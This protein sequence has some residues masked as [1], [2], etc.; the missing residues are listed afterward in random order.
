[1]NLKPDLLKKCIGEGNTLIQ[2][3]ELEVATHLE[4][5]NKA[6]SLAAAQRT[7]LHKLSVK[8]RLSCANPIK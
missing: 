5:E 1:M 3:S 6:K 8:F 2:K 7:F 4:T